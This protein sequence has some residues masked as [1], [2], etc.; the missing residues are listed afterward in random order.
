MCQVALAKNRI[1]LREIASILGNF[2][3]AI[4]SILFAK[5]Y[6]RS[7]KRFYIEQVKKSDF[8]LGSGCTLS[9]GA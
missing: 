6:Y 5:S 9:K 7:M 2:T 1:F 3:R 8:D 4:P